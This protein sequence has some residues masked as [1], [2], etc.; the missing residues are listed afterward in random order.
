MIT[1][2]TTVGILKGYRYDLNRSNNTMAK[3]MNTVITRRNFN[4]YAEDPAVATRCFQM[5]R[6]FMRTATQLTVNESIRRKY[7]VAWSAMDTISQDVDT[8]AKDTVF[9]SLLTGLNDPDASGRNALG[10]SMT[11]KAKSMVQTM[12][13]RFG[14]NYV[15]S[16]ADTLNVPFTWGP[17]KNPAYLDVTPLDETNP[18]HAAAFKYIA[19]PNKTGDAKILFTDDPAFAKEVPQPNP[20]YNEGFTKDVDSLAPDIPQDKLEDP[21]YGQFLKPDGMGT[22]VEGDAKKVPQDNPK[23]DPTYKFKYLKDDGSGTDNKDE[24]ASSLYY[25]GVSVDSMDPAALEKMDYFTGGEKKYQ[26]IGLGHKESNGDAVSST[27]FDTALQGVYYLGGYGTEKVTST[28]GEGASAYTKEVEV[29]N[30]II[31]QVARMGVILQRCDPDNGRFASKDDEAEFMALAHKFEDTKSL[32][33]QRWDEMD[34]ESGFLRDNTEL[35][36]D[37]AESVSQQ[38]M[39]LEDADPA[40]AIS[41]YMFARYCYDA[42]LK[43]GN[44]VLSQSLMDYMSL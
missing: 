7:D 2:T 3:R 34:T 25:R 17:K 4:S 18:D 9:Q 20:D 5:R 23:Y 42:A 22:N 29:P 10:Q 39:A 16:G 41:D 37:T 38:F 33:K 6:T 30:N 24:A 26:D 27:V 19:D 40:G 32:I 15:F 28:I 8:V 1:R 14:E 35:L 31:S 21:R 11:A 44:S 13:G 43:V 12:N 36:T